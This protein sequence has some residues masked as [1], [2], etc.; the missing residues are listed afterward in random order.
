[1]DTRSLTHFLKV[2]ELGSVTRAADALGMAQ[3]GLSRDIAMLER[4][5]GAKLFVRKA[6][7]VTLTEGGL[8]FRERA[9]ALLRD[10]NEL[11]QDI[12]LGS[13]TP[14]GHLSLG[15]PIS[16]V[17][18]LTSPFIERFNRAYPKVLLTVHEG[19]SDQLEALIRSGQID[20]AILMSAQRPIRNVDLKPLVTEDMYLVG[21]LGS[22]LNIQQPVGWSSLNDRPMILYSLPNQTR[23]KIDH[24]KRRYGLN[25]RTVAEVS[26]LPLLLDL[27][28]RGVGYAITPM[29]AIRHAIARKRLTAAPLRNV[30]VK[31]ALAVTRNRPYAKAIPEAER[32]IRELIKQQAGRTGAWTVI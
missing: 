6:R 3:P 11:K 15:L 16:M 17:Y 7:G 28:E 10:F 27:V 22:G 4:E 14:Y 1:M 23:L 8:I 2:A 20:I 31:W 13:R 5:V 32:L 12:V 19:I 18:V 21:P 30:S 26:S 25:F 29:G 9:F 24:A